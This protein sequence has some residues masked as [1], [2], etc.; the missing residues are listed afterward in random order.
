M[1]NK[2]FDKVISAGATVMFVGLI[3][4]AS[5][6]PFWALAG[7]SIGLYECCLMACRIA[8]K[9]ARK[10]RRRHYITATRFD[11]ERVAAQEFRWK[12]KEVS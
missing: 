12:M 10:Q 4:T 9:Q 2:G 11:M 1:K 7:L 3:Q 6:P 8:R 5:E